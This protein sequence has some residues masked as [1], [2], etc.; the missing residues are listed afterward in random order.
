MK[1]VIDTNV[2]ATTITTLHY[3]AAKTVGDKAARQH[4][5]ALLQVLELAPVT[6]AVIELALSST[7]PDFEDAVLIHAAQRIGAQAIITRN[8]R[9]FLP[10]PLQVY[11]PKAWLAAQFKP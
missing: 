11:E 2:C 5:A 9:D 6:G 3:I 7:M 4:I 1:V 8:A 10:G